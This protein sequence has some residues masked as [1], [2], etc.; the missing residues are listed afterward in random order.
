MSWALFL[1]IAAIIS[2]VFGFLARRKRLAMLGTPTLSCAQIADQVGNNGAPVECEVK[3]E[4]LAGPQGVLT[5]PL[6]KTPCVW[7]EVEVKR[8][9]RSHSN[10]R[11]RQRSETVDTYRTPEPFGL[12]DQTGVILVHPHEAQI[13]QPQ[14]TFNQRMSEDAAQNLYRQATGRTL[15]AGMRTYGFVFREA[16]I[17]PGRPLYALGQAGFQGNG[18]ELRKPRQGPYMISTRSEEQLAKYHTL[19]QQISFV[20]AAIFAVI[21][22][23]VLA[24]TQ[25]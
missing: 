13:D 19:R 21:A 4:V 9:Y 7:Y 5:S 15:R 20:F 14:Q 3:G 6:S 8:L 16:V 18:L 1:A 23:I 11:T 25:L 2:A 12:R 22:I 24:L 17:P 10:G